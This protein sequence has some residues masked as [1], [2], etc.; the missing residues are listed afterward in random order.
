MEG[1]KIVLHLRRG[2]PGHLVSL[3]TDAEGRQNYILHVGRPVPLV[4]RWVSAWAGILAPDRAQVLLPGGRPAPGP[5]GPRPEP[6]CDGTRC[7][8]YHCFGGA[9]TSVVAGAIHLGMLPQR[10]T[11]RQVA[12]F[13]L[14]DRTPT[15]E[16]GWPLYLGTDEKGRRV[17]AMG[18]G[19]DSRGATLVFDALLRA[20]GLDGQVTSHDTLACAGP[21]TKL[22]GYL[23]RRLGLVKPGRALAAVGITRDLPRLLRVVKQARN[24]S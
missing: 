20:L 13:P 2:R 19:R 24:S 9:H 23:S 5:P 3:G 17:Y 4:A 7:I 14:F 22:G 8:V 21:L 16:R 15:R 11:W 10:P 6:V 12:T 1:N 18:R